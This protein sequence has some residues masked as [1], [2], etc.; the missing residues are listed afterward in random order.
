MVHRHGMMTGRPQ[1]SDRHPGG[2]RGPPHGGLRGCRQILRDPVTD[3]A[4]LDTADAD[5]GS[6]RRQYPRRQGRRVTGQAQL[7]D[8]NRG[9]RPRPN[10]RRPRPEVPARPPGHPPGG[11]DRPGPYAARPHSHHALRP[12]RP[13]DRRRKSSGSIRFNGVSAR[14]DPRQLGRRPGHPANIT[15]FQQ[16]VPEVPLGVA[17]HGADRPHHPGG[18]PA[19]TSAHAR[20]AP[21]GSTPASPGKRR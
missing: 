4:D 14:A 15:A 18:R 1:H 10:R 8:A 11:S 16:I 6:R 21:R 5:G 17:T 20:S 13:R 19:T 2:I 7:R 9:S 12:R 3:A